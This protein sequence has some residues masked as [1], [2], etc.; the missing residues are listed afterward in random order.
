MKIETLLYQ[1]LTNDTSLASKLTT[2]NSLPAVFELLAPESE[3]GGWSGKQTPRIE[4]WVNRT[5]DPERRVSGQ[6]M[7]SVIHEETSNEVSAN[8]EDDVRRI[9]DGAT[10]RP[11]GETIILQWDT[12]ELYDEAAEYRGFD[13]IFDLIAWPTGLT[14][15]PDPIKALRSW[16]TSR[17]S[18]IQVDPLTWS[19]TDATPALY[20]RMEGVES[21]EML[22][23][24]SWITAR[25][26]G[27]LLAKTPNTRFYWLRSVVE[28]ASID[29]AVN[30]EDGS[31]MFIDSVQSSNDADPLRDG[32]IMI[33]ARFG[34][35]INRS[36]PMLSNIYIS[37]NAGEGMIEK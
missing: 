24:G 17:W 13:L 18:D 26:R 27:H 8:I 22:A 28:R 14:Y 34:V 23:W 12:V 33:T 1:A 35:L 37:G 5:E 2:Y 31:R 25:F 19:P 11:D 29:R 16:S 6:V 3:M 30:L 7:V 4:Y 32:Q 10:F 20:W 15:S 21:E 9:L 36:G